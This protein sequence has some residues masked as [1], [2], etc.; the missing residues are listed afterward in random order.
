MD[1]RIRL[2]QPCLHEF[3]HD[4]MYSGCQSATRWVNDITGLSDSPGAAGTLYYVLITANASPGYLASTPSVQASH[5]DTGLIGAVT[6][7]NPTSP[8][9]R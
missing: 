7:I 1:L 5:N 8:S 2:T 9:R 6:N 4:G 3:E